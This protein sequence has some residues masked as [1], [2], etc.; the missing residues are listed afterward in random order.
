M[1]LCE[2]SNR[3]MSFARSITIPNCVLHC[4]IL[5]RKDRSILRTPRHPRWPPPQLSRITA[6]AISPHK[7]TR[8]ETSQELG[9]S[10]VVVSLFKKAWMWLK[11]VIPLTLFVIGAS[12]FKSQLLQETRQNWI[13]SGNFAATSMKAPPQSFT[14]ADVVLYRFQKV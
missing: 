3:T 14:W 10:N 7:T 12:L 13:L 2:A 8:L 1:N 6:R 9:K 5:S 11:V 4:S